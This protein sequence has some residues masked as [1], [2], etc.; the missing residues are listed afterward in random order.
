M[1]QPLHGCANSHILQEGEDS[2]WL[3]TRCRTSLKKGKIPSFSVVNNMHV[4]PVP[5]ELSCLNVTEK[6]LICR[7]K[8]L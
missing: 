6:R 3:C 7:V 8:S 2:V 5:P 1:L 4:A